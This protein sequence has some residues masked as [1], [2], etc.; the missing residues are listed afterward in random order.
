VVSGTP[1]YSAETIRKVRD[2]IE[3]LNYVPSYAANALRKR[4][5]RTI[6][7][8]ARDPF[9]IAGR[10]SHS[11]P[12]RL[13]AGI[14]KEADLSHHKVMHFPGAIRESDDAA[15]FLNG[16]I[17]GLIICASR[18]DERP[19]TLAKA[20]LPV[21]MV[22]RY[23]DL[24][25]GVGSV[26]TDESAIVAHGLGYLHRLG[27]RQIAY[28]AGPAMDTGTWSAESP[29]PDDVAE[30]RL[31]GY[32]DW[33]ETHAP[34]V[35]PRWVTT[36]SWEGADISDTIRGWAEQGVTAVFGGNDN[37]ARWVLDAASSLGIAVP[38]RLSVLG[39]DN[40]QTCNFTNPPLS[41]I[42]IP[43]HEIGRRAVRELLAMMRGEAPT[44]HRIDLHGLEVT[45]RAS[46]GPCPSS[47]L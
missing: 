23:F 22:A 33:M 27:H 36:P 44:H 40:D 1:G 31:K 34:D 20:G 38:D 21:V 41:S 24:P 5:T 37:L 10:D 12:D 14:L 35:E 19:A 39:I 46:T 2:A 13:W 11:F 16:Q 8:C 43:I 45:L 15:E 32:Q 17:D 29:N 47:L 26:A 42:D 25:A 4:S 28:V 30:A 3:Q 18:Y 9:E 6:G 7:V